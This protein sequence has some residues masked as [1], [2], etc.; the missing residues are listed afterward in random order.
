V[1]GVTAD[2]QN[3]SY[4]RKSWIASSFFFKTKT[5]RKKQSW[6][7]PNGFISSF[8]ISLTTMGNLT[9]LTGAKCHHILRSN[10]RALSLPVSKGF[11]T[12]I[13]TPSEGV[14]DSISL[15]SLGDPV[16]DIQQPISSFKDSLLPLQMANQRNA[17]L[18]FTLILTQSSLFVTIQQLDIFVMMFES[19]FLVHFI[20]QT[21]A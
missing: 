2:V 14:S 7:P 15:P 1:D 10:Q 13:F 20:K 18:K 8:L 3:H 9:M 12:S 6:T 11:A 17:I 21:N 16:Q 5:L 19:L 4:S